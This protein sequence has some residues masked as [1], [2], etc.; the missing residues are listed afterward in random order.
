VALDGAGIIVVAD[1][2]N[3]CIRQIQYRGGGG[4][5]GHGQGGGGGGD[6]YVSTIAGGPLGDGFS[7][8]GGRQVVKSLNRA[9]LNRKP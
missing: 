6:F 3:H 8:L 7:D 5:G 4:E 1:T 9:S 2:G